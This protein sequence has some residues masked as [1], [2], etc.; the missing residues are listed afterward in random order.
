[1]VGLGDVRARLSL[2]VV[3]LCSFRAAFAA[4]LHLD[5]PQ[6][7]LRSALVEVSKAFDIQLLYSADLVD[8]LVGP[9]LRGEFTVDSALERLL[10]DTGLTFSHANP[11]TVLIV[12]APQTRVFHALQV[13]GTQRVPATGANGSRDVLATERS[14][15]YAARGAAVGNPGPQALKDI[16]RAIS[17]IGQQQMQ[18]QNLVELADAL[19]QL[20][21]VSVRGTPLDGVEVQVRAFR[22]REFQ[23]DGGAVRDRDADGIFQESLDIYD[24]LELLRGANGLANGYTSP[25]GVLN[26]VRKRPLDHPQMVIEAQAGSWNAYRAMLDVSSPLNASGSLRGRSVISGVDKDYFHDTTH[27]RRLGWYGIAEAD[28]GRDTLVDV[29]LHYLERDATPWGAGGIPLSYTGDALAVPRHA[30]F[31]LPW[32]QDDRQ[33]LNLFATVDTRL[34]PDWNARLVLDHV[35]DDGALLETSGLAGYLDEASGEGL[36][37]YPPV[38]FDTDRRQLLADVKINGR[39]SWLG[40]EQ[41][42]SFGISHARDRNAVVSYE[43]DQTDFVPINIYHF[44]AADYPAPQRVARVGDAPTR[45]Q[46]ERASANVTLRLNPWRPLGI[47][48]SYRWS[49][50]SDRGDGRGHGRDEHVAPSYFGMTYA[51]ADHWTVYG[52]WANVYESNEPLASMRGKGLDPTYGDNYEAGVK[53]ASQGGGL[54]AAFALYRVERWNFNRFLGLREGDPYCCYDNGSDQRNISDGFSIELSGTPGAGVQLAASY[55]YNHNIVRGSDSSSPGER[56]SAITPRHLFRFWSTWRPRSEGWRRLDLGGGIH[57][58]SRSAWRDVF[59]M[60]EQGGSVVSEPQGG[61]ALFS[62][63]V[64]WQLAAHWHLAL[65]VE[66]LLDHDYFASRESNVGQADFRG[67]PRSF[68]LR[69]RGEF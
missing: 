24:R 44:D 20:P 43:T 47:I 16:P 15:S 21:G 28:V 45:W 10:A 61:Y 51:L 36:G 69:L 30:S 5:L 60:T 50:Y 66:N 23:V 18:D 62:A 53:Y 3:L 58:Q 39:F 11:Q 31:V 2:V 63:R 59:V 34:G 9:P 37:F 7:D 4:G 1:M 54:Q 8:G 68:T 17:V 29:G 67:E 32:E 35:R 48:G 14:G 52:S 33:M 40:L 65:N 19:W 55:G 57:A 56:Y 13:T 26:L 25:A 64:G 38:A 41:H 12:R 46:T 6:E 49:R 27:L 42:L 22:L